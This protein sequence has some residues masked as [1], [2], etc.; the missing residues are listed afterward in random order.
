[1]KQYQPFFVPA[2]ELSRLNQR[3]SPR[4]HAPIRKRKQARPGLGAAGHPSTGHTPAG[5]LSDRTL[6]TIMA[7]TMASAGLGVVA[8]L[9]TC[10]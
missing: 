7:I 8:W 6:G 1:M 3:R 4:R 10:I 5:I 9:V 2:A